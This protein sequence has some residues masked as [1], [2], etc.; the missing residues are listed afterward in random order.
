M[1]VARQRS[2]NS[3][4]CVR[5]SSSGVHGGL[6]REGVGAKKFGVSFE[7][8]GIPGIGFSHKLGRQC[9]SENCSENTLEF[10]ELL[11][12][13]PFHSESVFFKIGVVPRFLIFS[14]DY[15]PP[16][17]RRVFSGAVGWGLSAPKSQRFFAICDCDA[18]RGAQK[19]Q[20][21]P[22]QEKAMLHCDFAALRFKGAMESH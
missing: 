21:F 2:I 20:R 14:A 8:Q 3:N 6:P 22:K 1:S 15:T 16:N 5:I 18:H 11:R 13:W 19:S 9:H 17:P 4:F 10:R 7:A 12:E